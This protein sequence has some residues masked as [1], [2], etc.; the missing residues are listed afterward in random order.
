MKTSGYNIESVKIKKYDRMKKLFFLVGMAHA[1]TTFLGHFAKYVKKN[2][3]NHWDVAK[4]FLE[5]EKYLHLNG[6]KEF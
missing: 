6:K 5:L 4:V 3:A 1:L 2:F